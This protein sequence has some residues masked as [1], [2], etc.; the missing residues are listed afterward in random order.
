M[1]QYCL[2]MITTLTVLLHLFISFH[3]FP[4]LN[5]I[6]IAFFIGGFLCTGYAN[7]LDNK[8]SQYRM[9]YERSEYNPLYMNDFIRKNHKKIFM[10]DLKGFFCCQVLMAICM[11]LTL[12][13]AI[14]S[15]KGERNYIFEK[16]ILCSYI[17]VFCLHFGFKN[18]YKWKYRSAFRYVNKNGIWK[19]FSYL[20]RP[21]KWKV[22]SPFVCN[23]DTDCSSLFQDVEKKLANF[24]YSFSVKDDLE[25]VLFYTKR[26]NKE[27]NILSIIYMNEYV[28]G[29]L[30]KL[31]DAF[32]KYWNT[33][34]H[35]P[36]EQECMQ[37]MI[38]FFVDKKNSALRK[39]FL[40]DMVLC[41]D[42]V[43]VK[44]SFSPS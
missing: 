42:L 34:L 9:A 39:N 5:Y 10:A 22:K 2:F 21:W 24:G 1:I 12:I 38:L 4:F 28:D 13:Y 26:R 17:M 36:I 43:Q 3:I 25:N 19:P 14:P 18:Y 15:Y 23:I 30:E 44:M 20:V 7:R 29:Y 16:I 40:S 6:G 27:W 33:F 35:E 11:G 41:Q 8:R 37:I 32:E 31:N